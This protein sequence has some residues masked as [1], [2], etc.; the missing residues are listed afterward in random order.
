MQHVLLA[1]KEIVIY[2][3]LLLGL[4][5]EESSTDWLFIG[6]LNVPSV[7]YSCHSLL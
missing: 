4:G 1:R 7:L 2:L 5:N 6:I 3:Y